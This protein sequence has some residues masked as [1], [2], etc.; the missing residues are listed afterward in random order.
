M[1]KSLLFLPLL[2]LASNVAAQELRGV[3]TDADNNPLV[4]ASVYWAETTIGASTSAT[5][6][7]T[8]HRVKNYDRLVAS[9][10]GYVNDTI[11]IA[12]GVAEQNFRLRSEG[13]DIEGVVVEYTPVCLIVLH[14]IYGYVMFGIVW[15]IAILAIA[16]KLLWVTCPK[17]ISSVLYIVMGWT[18]IMALPQIYSALAGAA[19]FWLLA[20]GIFYT[21]G[22]VIY[23]IKMP[24]F[25]AKHPNFGTHEIFHVFVMAGSLCHFILM[26]NFV[27]IM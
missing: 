17:W 14:N 6:A 16:F 21:V 18:C 5:G 7:Y 26:Y 9:Y 11:R 22:G 27:A 13:V 4:G 10:L 25:N 23:A 12:D 19:F 15:G 24:A 20:G 8:V 2:G 3:V 1:K